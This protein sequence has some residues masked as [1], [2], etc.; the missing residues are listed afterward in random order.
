MPAAPA[1]TNANRLLNL[2]DTA[3]IFTSIYR[4]FDRRLT[5]NF[6]NKRP[7]TIR[8]KNIHKTPCGNSAIEELTAVWPGQLA[9]QA[10]LEF[11]EM[12]LGGLRAQVCGKPLKKQILSARL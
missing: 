12:R 1:H 10:T 2:K 6:Q 3:R 5:N 8:Q 4:F 9:L 11:K 7:E